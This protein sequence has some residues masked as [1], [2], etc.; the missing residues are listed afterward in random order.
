MMP[1]ADLF[2]IVFFNQAGRER[3]AEGAT[4]KQ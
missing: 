2:F 1:A 3:Q 4:A